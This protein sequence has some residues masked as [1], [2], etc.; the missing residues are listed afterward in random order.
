MV[1]FVE[2]YGSIERLVGQGTFLS[3]HMAED[4]VALV[5]LDLMA[6][7]VRVGIS[8]SGQSALRHVVLAWMK[9]RRSGKAEPR[10]VTV[11]ADDLAMSMDTDIDNVA[12]ALT[13]IA[14]HLPMMQEVEW[15]GWIRFDLTPWMPLDDSRLAGELDRLWSLDHVA[16]VQEHCE[17]AKRF[18]D[19][20][21]DALSAP[22]A[23]RPEAVARI[24]EL[25]RRRAVWEARSRLTRSDAIDHALADLWTFHDEVAELEHLYDC[26]V[27]LLAD[28]GSYVEPFSLIWR[29][30]GAAKLQAL[31]LPS[32]A[33]SGE[34]VTSGWQ[35]VS[36]NPE[37]SSVSDP[38]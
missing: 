18:L 7:G 6:Q 22:D 13:A 30:Q 34:D 32:K 24:A 4:V 9:Q 15:Y 14:D 17:E 10:M 28:A 11:R 21:L 38:L 31:S 2:E 12:A 36:D 8:E 16:T 23:L 35:L 29:T 5:A 26:V 37:R 25:N 27:G 20:Q 33:L 3:G 1:S 19:Q